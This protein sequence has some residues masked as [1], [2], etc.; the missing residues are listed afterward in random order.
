MRT[1]PG[2]IK[3]PLPWNAVEEKFHRLAEPY[4]DHVLRNAMVN[5]VANLDQ[6]RISELTRLFDQVGKAADIPKAL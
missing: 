1:Y 4:A 5:A 3:S 6:I 2:F